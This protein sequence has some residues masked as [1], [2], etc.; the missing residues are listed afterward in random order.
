MN[1]NYR[2]YAIYAASNIVRNLP[3]LTYNLNIYEVTDTELLKISA[4]KTPQ[5]VLALV[6]IPT[7]LG[8]ADDLNGF[9]IYLDGIQDPGNLG[10]I[11]RTAD[12]FGIK[13][14]I[15][16]EDTVEVY[17]PKVVQATMGSLSRYHIVYT[18]LKKL[19]NDSKKQVFGAVLD[20]ENFY[21]TIWP[22]NG[23]L[24]LGNEGNGISPGLLP[25]IN[26]AVTIPGAGKTESLNV[27]V[28]CAIFCTEIS[29][30]SL[31]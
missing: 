6:N 9:D 28:S 3:K 31:K 26:K 17:N 12:W 30:N 5:N 20:G 10:T 16:S 29:R 2:I 1:S 14:I 27:A 15:C 19:I 7:V 8:K 23:I 18:D 4:L 25:L 11:I 13:N 22:V 21:N 24:L